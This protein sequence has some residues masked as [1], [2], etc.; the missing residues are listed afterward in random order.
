MTR[1]SSF[2]VAALVVACGATTPAPANDGGTLPE[3]KRH[4]PTATAC[5]P[6]RPPTA[7]EPSAAGCKTDLE[8]AGDGGAANARCVFDLLAGKNV[9]STDE[10][11]SDAACGPSRVCAC[12]L[13]PSFGANRCLNAACRTD[14]DCGVVGKGWCSPSG[15]DVFANCPLPEPGS[16][17]YFCHQPQDECVDD[18]ACGDGGTR[19]CLFSPSK[20]HFA[21]VTLVCSR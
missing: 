1:A 6:T 13:A 11:A 8:C 16:L 21:C 17:G 12:R 2:V 19:R 20:G 3:P 7:P 9:C 10:C 5:D 14:G 15:D 4:R 18:D